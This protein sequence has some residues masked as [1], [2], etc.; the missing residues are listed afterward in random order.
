M[1]PFGTRKVI[2]FP[3]WVNLCHLRIWCY[4]FGFT[5]HIYEKKFGFRIFWWNDRFWSDKIDFSHIFELFLFYSERRFVISEFG[6]ECIN[7][8]FLFVYLKKTE[9]LWNNSKFP[10]NTR[11]T[12]IH[13][14]SVLGYTL[15]RHFGTRKFNNIPKWVSLCH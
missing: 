1:R 5:R 7:S 8:I 4:F 13:Q 11:K 14:F 2:N 9:K 6:L 3:K 15:K 12:Q 10:K